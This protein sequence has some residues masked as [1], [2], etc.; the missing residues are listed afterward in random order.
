MKLIFGAWISLNSSVFIFDFDRR[1]I[2]FIIA[3]VYVMNKFIRITN[4]I[5]AISFDKSWR[6]TNCK[7]RFA[8]QVTKASSQVCFIYFCLIDPFEE[9]I[10]EVS[11]RSVAIFFSAKY[12]TSTVSY[13]STSNILRPIIFTRRFTWFCGTATTQCQARNQN[14]FI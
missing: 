8:W 2:V 1:I 3:C 14:Y 4:I 11:I 10:I 7:T 6:T 5:I 9:W 13:Y 12:G